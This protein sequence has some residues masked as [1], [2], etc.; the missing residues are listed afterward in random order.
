V[1]RTWWRFIE[2][3]KMNRRIS[4]KEFRIS[5]G[6]PLPY[7]VSGATCSNVYPKGNVRFFG[8]PCSVFDIRHSR[9]TRAGFSIL[10]VLVALAVFA[11]AAGGLLAV[12]GNHMRDVSYLQDQARAVRIARRE[13]DALQ[14]MSVFQTLEETGEEGRFSWVSRMTDKLPIEVPGEEFAD[15]GA[16]DGSI[17]AF[18]EVE[19][20]WSETEGGAPSK[21]ARL[22]AL[23]DFPEE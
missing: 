15:D 12:L 7:R 6:G 20:A 13:M 22:K 10:E 1:S 3:G 23:Y 8:G 14:R 18:L 4:N 9:G 2:E 17:L 19:V 5:K 11:I 21:R 16:S